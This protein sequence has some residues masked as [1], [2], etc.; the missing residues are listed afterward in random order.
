MVTLAERLWRWIVSPENVGSIPTRH[1][2]SRAA[3]NGGPCAGLKSRTSPFDP[4]AAHH[5]KGG[6]AGRP[7]SRSRKPMIA[8]MLWRST[9]PA[10][11]QHGEQSQPGWTEFAKLVMPE[12]AW[13]PTPPLSAIHEEDQAQEATDTV[14]GAPGDES[15]SGQAQPATAFSRAYRLN[16]TI[17]RHS[18]RTTLSSPTH[19]IRSRLQ[20]SSVSN[21]P[22]AML[23]QFGCRV[24]SDHPAH[25]TMS[26][27]KVT[28][29][30]RS[31][32]P[33]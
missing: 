4:E 20:A 8:E 14:V 10:T 21:W 2:N 27:V 6:F 22:V 17:R 15:H 24:T 30:K 13:G 16:L 23:Q 28:L 29:A 7:L 18:A 12:M 26:N 5:S 25:H 1:P 3:S 31:G 9:L 33:P 32:W 19:P 11:R